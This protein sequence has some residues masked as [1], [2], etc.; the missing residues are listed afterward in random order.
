MPPLELPLTQNAFTVFDFAN[1]ELTIL[2]SLEWEDLLDELGRWRIYSG[3]SHKISSVM[4]LTATFLMVTS[5]LWFAAAYIT[6][7]RS[8]KPSYVAN[9]SIRELLGQPLG[10]SMY[11][12]SV[13]TIR[14]PL[15]LGFVCFLMD[16]GYAVC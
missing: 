1:F 3:P 12:S 10:L 7:G 8:N 14:L 16:T 13:N 15:Q 2:P 4:P 11:A 6:P 9:C 5:T